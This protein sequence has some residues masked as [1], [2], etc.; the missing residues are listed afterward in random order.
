MT[1]VEVVVDGRR[2]QVHPA[3]DAD[4]ER[5]GVRE[6]EQPARFFERLPYLDDHARVEARASISRFKSSGMKSRRIAD[7]DSSIQSYSAGEY[8]QKCWWVSMRTICYC[9]G[10][11]QYCGIGHLQLVIDRLLMRCEFE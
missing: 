4:N 3:D 10:Y 11:W 6:L 7:I 8:R 1:T 5:V 9:I 2:L